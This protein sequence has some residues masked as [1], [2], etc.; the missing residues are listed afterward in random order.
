MHLRTVNSIF[1]MQGE[2]KECFDMII[3]GHGWDTALIGGMSCLKRWMK[4]SQFLFCLD[5]GC[6][7]HVYQ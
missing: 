7:G 1:E 6:R 3:N 2:L 5:K 4:D